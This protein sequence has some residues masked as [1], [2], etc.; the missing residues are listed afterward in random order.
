M[1]A[2]VVVTGE[3]GATIAGD[4]AVVA[5][6]TEEALGDMEMEEAPH[7]VILEAV[8]AVTEGMLQ[9]L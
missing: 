8:V 4:M 6:D 1:T 5:E 7:A 2:V 9:N 3:I